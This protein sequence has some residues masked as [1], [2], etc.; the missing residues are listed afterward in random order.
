MASPPTATCSRGVQRTAARPGRSAFGSTIF[1]PRRAR[2]FTRL[3][4]MGAETCSRRG[5]ICAKPGTRLYGAHSE[6]SG[7]TWTSN[8]LLYES[9]DG[10]I[11]QCC[12]PSVAFT[13]SGRLEVMWRNCLAGARD[14]YLM[15]SEGGR[16]FSKPE[17]LGQDTWM[18]N[19]CPM[20][21]GGLTH[22]EGRTITAWRRGTE[23]FTA[24]PGKPETRLGEG[25]DVTLAASEGQIY[26]LWVKGTQLVAWIGGRTEI[27][28]EKSAFPALTALPNGGVLASWEENG[29]ISLRPLQ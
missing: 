12:H 25:K 13:E 23:I 28:A 15:R 18:I 24:E 26:A 7:A 14:L 1:R 17:K 9:P 10:T 22:V 2:V 6:D 8:V 27:L 19:A 4:P 21:G 29:G 5:S 20:D 11:C 16:S 3:R